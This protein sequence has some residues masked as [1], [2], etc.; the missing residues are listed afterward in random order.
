M[1][2]GM[3]SPSRLSRALTDARPGVFSAFC[4]VAAFGTY[5]CMYAFRK[6]F[7]AGTFTGQTLLG[8]EA[9]TAHFRRRTPRT[10]DA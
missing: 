2:R 5:F 1:M 4:I 10:S 7:T 3:R 8:I 6:P 9:K